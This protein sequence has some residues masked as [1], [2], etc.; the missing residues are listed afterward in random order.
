MADAITSLA[1]F[2]A[3][4]AEEDSLSERIVDIVETA[5]D[6]IE[7]MLAD[8]DD[9]ARMQVIQKFLPMA[10]RI[11][12]TRHDSRMEAIADECRKQIAECIMS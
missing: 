5:L 8:G 12:Q 11:I 1:E 10:Q 4:I 9:E 3:D 2:T 7:D 6:M